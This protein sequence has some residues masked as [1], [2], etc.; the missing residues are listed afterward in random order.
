MTHTWGDEVS[1]TRLE[2]DVEIITHEDPDKGPGVRWIESIS[3]QVG[4]AFLAIE[5]FRNSNGETLAEILTRDHL[6]SNYEARR[7]GLVIP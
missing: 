7:K 6:G 4:S 1:H 2:M 3:F 5:D